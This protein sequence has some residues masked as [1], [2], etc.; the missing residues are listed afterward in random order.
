MVF[1]LFKSSEDKLKEHI[2]KTYDNYLN[3]LK[4]K[5]D[6]AHSCNRKLR[7]NKSKLLLLAPSVND[8]EEIINIFSH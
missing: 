5:N 1:G 8:N 3:I 7:I 2:S 6:F 4:K